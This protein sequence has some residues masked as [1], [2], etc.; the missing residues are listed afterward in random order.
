MSTTTVTPEVLEQD[1]S[2]PVKDAAVPVQPVVP[3]APVIAPV[4]QKYS[5][6]P[7]DT[8]GRPIGGLQVIKYT[9]QEELVAKLTHNHEESIRG[10]RDVRRKQRLGITDNEVL[11]AELEKAAAP[12]QFTEKALTVEE[13]F[14]I[15]KQLNDPEKFTEARDR[16][17][18]SSLGVKPQVLRDTLNQNTLQTRQLV[19]RQNAIEWM[20]QNPSFY[21]CSEN[22]TT[23][24]EWMAKSGLEPTVRN[25]EY[26]QSK[27]EEAGLLLTSPI[28]R[29]V[30]PVAVTPVEVVPES[31]APVVE[32]TRISE[33]PIPQSSTPVVEKRQSHVPSSLNNNNSSNAG[34]TVLTGVAA[35]TLA[36]VDKMP[37]DIYKQMLMTNPEFVKRVNELEA[38]RPPRP[39]IS[40]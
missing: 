15:S 4:E 23:V 29:E 13:R 31:Q 7:K 17:F 12:I 32:S 6:Q 1:P 35:L 21:Q 14:E 26:A 33:V 11:P 39:R 25:F 34:V 20:S 19:A 10:M 16:L 22:V 9:T 37:S 5:Y 40:R 36:D 30:P 2:M 3:E 38:S 24:C 28:V 18:E 8:E 27:M